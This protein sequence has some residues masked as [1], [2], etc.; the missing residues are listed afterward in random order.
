MQSELRSLQREVGIS[1][2]YVTHDQEEALTMADRIAVMDRGRALQ[3]ATPRTIYERPASRFVAG[4][5][6]DSSFLDG[7][8]TDVAAAGHV[9]IELA[10]GES[11]AAVGAVPATR[12][13]TVAVRPEN[14]RLVPPGAAASVDENVVKVTVTAIEYAGSDTSFLLRTTS[15]GDLRARQPSLDVWNRPDLV[16]GSAVLASFA[17]GHAVVLHE[18]DT[19]PGVM[20]EM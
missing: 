6:G 9:R 15:G 4:F 1:F 17:P 10:S 11:I 19:S 13:V 8:V 3:I 14:V 20:P 16:P 18:S 2:V 5:I 7:T 12:K